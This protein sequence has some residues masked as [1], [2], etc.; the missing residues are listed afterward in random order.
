[1]KGQ[2]Q[3]VS[4][5]PLVGA[6]VQVARAT[7]LD[8]GMLTDGNGSY[9]PTDITLHEQAPLTTDGTGKF[10]LGLHESDM[11]V[12][13]NLFELS[14]AS[15][16]PAGMDTVGPSYLCRPGEVDLEVRT[17]PAWAS[18]LKEAQTAEAL[19][20]EVTEPPAIQ[21]LGAKE[22][23]GWAQGLVSYRFELLEGTKRLW[24]GVTQ[25]PKVTFPAAA[26]EDFADLKLRVLVAQNAVSV[27]HG[28]AA[29][30]RGSHA[31]PMG[32]SVLYD[33]TFSA[34]QVGTLHP[35]S[36]GR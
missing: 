35:V 27:L 5:N 7:F 8:G 33:H 14:V 19:T 9:S 29:D 6:S 18:A 36:R 16:A 1:M 4:G 13:P 30:V 20:I 24:V 3:D 12:I 31:S 11:Y 32:Y 15:G 22:S 25:T 10:S 21:K 17:L 34:P 23:G 2:A 26:L 28:G